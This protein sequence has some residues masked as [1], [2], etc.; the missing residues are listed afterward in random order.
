[1]GKDKVKKAL[2]AGRNDIAQIHAANAIMQKNNSLNYLRMSSR[3]D[4]VAGKL[5]KLTENDLV[6]S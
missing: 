3:I 4:A 6:N 1:M 5:G 2:Q